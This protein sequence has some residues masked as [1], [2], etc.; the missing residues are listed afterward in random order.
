MTSTG[1]HSQAL[2]I[3]LTQQFVNQTGLDLNPAQTLS[4]FITLDLFICLSES[5]FI[6]HKVE[7]ISV[8]TSEVCEY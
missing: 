2:L 7:L 4:N 8:M 5:Q 1:L 6:H 3:I